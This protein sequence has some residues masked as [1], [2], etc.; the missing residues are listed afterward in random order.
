[1]LIR[2]LPLSGNFLC[3]STTW[4][5]NN[6]RTR[7]RSFSTSFLTMLSVQNISKQYRRRASRRSSFNASLA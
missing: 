1:M 4:A 2:F 5:P 7:Y 6:S 3:N